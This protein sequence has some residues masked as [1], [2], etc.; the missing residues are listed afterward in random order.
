MAR[1]TEDLHKPEM[2]LGIVQKYY[3]EKAPRKRPK[4]SELGRYARSIGY[5]IGNHIFQKSPDVRAYLD[6][7]AEEDEEEICLSVAVYDTLDT[8]KFVSVNNTPQKLRQALQE[9]DSYYR[10][11]TVS[12]GKVFETNKELK[13]KNTRISAENRKLSAE[14]KSLEEGYKDLKSKFSELKNMNASLREI[15]DTWVNPEIANE[16]L[17]KEGTLKNTAG[18]IKEDALEEKTFTGSSD[19]NALIKTMYRKVDSE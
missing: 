15:V 10:Q 8:E 11:V 1:K 3:A 17:K 7:M 16:L 5:D 2:L 12:A 19:I 18:V 13:E 9:R 4:Y 14:I 6:K